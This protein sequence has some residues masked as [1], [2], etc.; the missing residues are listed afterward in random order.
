MGNGWKIVGFNVVDFGKTLYI[1]AILCETYQNATQSS[2]ANRIS[3][4]EA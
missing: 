3:F 1:A 2:A 4:S